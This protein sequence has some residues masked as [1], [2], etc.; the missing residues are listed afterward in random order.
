MACSTSRYRSSRPRP[1]SSGTL[2]VP[3]RVG[4][5]RTNSARENCP[6]ILRSGW[7]AWAGER[8]KIPCHVIFRTLERSGSA[9]TPRGERGGLAQKAE[10]SPEG[11]LGEAAQREGL[12]MPKWVKELVARACERCGHQFPIYEGE[13]VPLGM[14]E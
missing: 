14:D 10:V 3:A 1:D 13:L 8:L 5:A 2:T 4:T 9:V 7:R 6:G 12:R 11:A